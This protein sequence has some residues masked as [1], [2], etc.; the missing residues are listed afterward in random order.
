M[1][2]KPWK[3]TCSNSHPIVSDFEYG[4]LTH[5]FHIRNNVTGKY[6]LPDD[7]YYIEVFEQI[8]GDEPKDYHKMT[9]VGRVVRGKFTNHFDP[10]QQGSFVWYMFV[11]VPKNA[12]TEIELTPA[13]KYSIV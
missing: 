5:T 1:T 8:G 4:Y 12:E 2:L 9:S 7:A 6:G 13:I 11:Y 10:T 3:V